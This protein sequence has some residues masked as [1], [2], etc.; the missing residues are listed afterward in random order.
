MYHSLNDV[1]IVQ[2]QNDTEHLLSNMFWGCKRE[3]LVTRKYL[4]FLQEEVKFV[5]KK[6]G[7]ETAEIS[8]NIDP[9]KDPRLLV[10]K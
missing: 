7:P 1:N 10:A 5:W 6:I 4:Q 2:Y 8:R 9:S 3:N